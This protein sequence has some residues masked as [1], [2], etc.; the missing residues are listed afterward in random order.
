MVN[1][2]EVC[3][4]LKNLNLRELRA[5]GGV[6]G[7]SYPR[8]SSIPEDIVESWL[9]GNDNVLRA[10]PDGGDSRTWNAL[11]RALESEGHRGVAL[12]VKKR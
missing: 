2:S 9:K 7:L 12:E 8:I 10:G 3:H 5:V 4:L 1:H 6:L 11:I